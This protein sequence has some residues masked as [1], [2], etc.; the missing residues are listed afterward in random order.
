MYDLQ[1][2]SHTVK[3]KLSS[4]LVLIFNDIRSIFLRLIKKT[5]FLTNLPGVTAR[6]VISIYQRRW[7]VEIIFKELKSG[8]GLGEHQ[9]T[10]NE[11]RVKNSLGIA[12]LAYVFLLRIRRQDIKPGDSWSIF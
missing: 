8:L 3:A 10:K 11:K 4:M 12:I 5:Y 1:Q 6:P 9:I 7:S 2:S